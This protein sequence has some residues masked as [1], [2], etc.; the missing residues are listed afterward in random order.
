MEINMERIRERVKVANASLQF[1]MEEELNLEQQMPDVESIVGQTFQFILRQVTKGEGKVCIQGDLEYQILYKAVKGQ[2]EVMGISG[3]YPVNQCLMMETMPEWD[4]DTKVEVG[5]TTVKRMNSRKLSVFV[6]LEMHGD[7]YQV[8]EAEY[9]ED[10]KGEVEKQKRSIEI[11]RC[12]ESG[13]TNMS[14]KDVLTL[15]SNRPDIG[16]IIYQKVQLRGVEIN[17]IDGSLWLKGE[18]FAFIVYEAQSEEPH[19]EYMEMM[20]PIE[21]RVECGNCQQEECLFFDYAVIQAKAAEAPNEDGEVRDVHITIEL[22]VSYCQIRNEEISYL[23][24]AY[25][26]KSQLNPEYTE[27][28]MKK[29]CCQQMMRVKVA[30]TFM[31]TGEDR[32]LVIYPTS[33]DVKIEEIETVEGGVLLE[34]VVIAKILYIGTIRG[35][36]PSMI[37]LS[38]P[39]HQQISMPMVSPKKEMEFKV[40]ADTVLLSANILDG[41][42]AEVKA[43]VNITI[44]GFEKVHLPMMTSLKEEELQEEKRPGMVGYIIGKEDT[45]WKLAKENRTTMES[46]CQINE[47]KEKELKPGMQILVCQSQ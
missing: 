34:G 27:V 11:S 16:R 30:D 32:L 7:A 40:R 17:L 18:V 39:F 26:L 20:S 31:P 8:Q 13:K 33:S 36:S 41:T 42:Q 21:G 22:E 10:V 28:D 12:T 38:I 45:L 4:V 9:I 25:A 43:S 1:P 29:L 6:L 19:V 14:M 24:D 46:I 2:T 15:P 35:Q 37:R 5:T 3:S 23:Q 47:L 44:C